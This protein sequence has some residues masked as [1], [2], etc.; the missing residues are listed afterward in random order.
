[1]SNI[2]ANTKRISGYPTR[3]L[4]EEVEILRNGQS[5]GNIP[6]MKEQTLRG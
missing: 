1:M 5:L 2:H 4:S 3:K 6:E